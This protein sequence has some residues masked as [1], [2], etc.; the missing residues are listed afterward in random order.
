MA[1]DKD[2]DGKTEEGK[3]SK[4]WDAKKGVYAGRRAVDEVKE[5]ESGEGS[6]KVVRVYYTWTAY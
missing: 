6:K 3:K 1:L 2:W 5:T 4:I